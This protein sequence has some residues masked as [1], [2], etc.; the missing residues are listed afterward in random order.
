LLKFGRW[1]L[2]ISSIIAAILTPPDV[3]S[4]IMMLV[5][6]NVLYFLSVGSAALFGRKREATEELPAT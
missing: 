4:Q 6:L 1:W 3:G 5:P 2:V